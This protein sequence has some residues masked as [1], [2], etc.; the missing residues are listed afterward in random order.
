MQTKVEEN[1]LLKAGIISF[2]MLSL[3]DTLLLRL[4]MTYNDHFSFDGGILGDTIN[5][6]SGDGYVPVSLQMA[7]A[8]TS[9]R[10]SDMLLPIDAFAEKF[11]ARKAADIARQILN[12]A[13]FSGSRVI[14]CD[15]PIP[16]GVDMAER[17]GNPRIS[18][19]MVRAYNIDTD[20]FPVR[21]DVLFGVT[22]AFD[23]TELERFSFDCN[24][25][26]AM[27]ANLER[28]TDEAWKTWSKLT[29][30]KVESRLA[31]D[32]AHNRLAQYLARNGCT[33]VEVSK[34]SVKQAQQ[35]Q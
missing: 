11:L 7:H 8:E 22:C 33:V 9:F 4:P 13:A 10:S 6:K 25:L 2:K 16:R 29:T 5:E 21:F 17:I 31:R 24:L 26:E 30:K 14:T 32:E 19:R 23:C 3:I 1:P 27:Y 15:L 20:T 35:H 18:L 34:P 12:A 28:E